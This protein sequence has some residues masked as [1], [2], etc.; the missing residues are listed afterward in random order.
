MSSRLTHLTPT[1][2]PLWDEYTRP[3]DIGLH[4]HFTEEEN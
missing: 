3:R 1:D 4:S 2:R